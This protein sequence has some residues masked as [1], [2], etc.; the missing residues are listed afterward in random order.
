MVARKKWVT[1]DC[2]SFQRGFD[3]H[4]QV[5]VIIIHVEHIK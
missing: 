5:N 3:K 2:I 1:S 4:R